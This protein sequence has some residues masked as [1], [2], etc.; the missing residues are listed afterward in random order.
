MG[1][2]AEQQ[3]GFMGTE[4]AFFHLHHHSSIFSTETQKTADFSRSSTGL[5]A[6]LP[7]PKLVNFLQPVY[8][9]SD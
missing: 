9:I 8:F 4:I 3:F 7:L 1:Q 5:S 6:V 2:V